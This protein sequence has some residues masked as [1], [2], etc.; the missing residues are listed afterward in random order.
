VPSTSQDI[1]RWY[2]LVKM[3]KELFNKG[4]PSQ[5]VEQYKIRYLLSELNNVSV[6]SC[7]K[8][9]YRD[10]KVKLIEVN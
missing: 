7:G 2:Q 4:C 5:L 3:K 8:E 9:V 1:L 6:N 10:N